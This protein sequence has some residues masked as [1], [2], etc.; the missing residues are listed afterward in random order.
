MRARILIGLSGVLTGFTGCITDS[1]SL[2]DSI[3]LRWNVPSAWH[4]GPS[5]PV[6]PR[7][8]SLGGEDLQA[9]IR[10]AYENNFDLQQARIRVEQAQLQTTIAGAAKRPTLQGAVD[11]SRSERRRGLVDGV[12]TTESEDYGL[13]LSASWELDL[14]G[15]LGSR[16]RAAIANRDAVQAQYD[17]A[18]LSLAGQVAKSWFNVIEAEMQRKI[19]RDALQTFENN[20]DLM[21]DRFNLGMNTA[22]DVQL[23]RANTAGAQRLLSANKQQRDALI[24]AL[25]VLLGTYPENTLSTPTVLPETL[26]PIPSGMP[27]EL[28]KRRPDVRAVEQRVRAAAFTQDEKEKDR[29]PSIRLTGRAG[30][31]SDELSSIAD[32]D[33]RF[34]NLA[35]GLTQPIFE[36]GRLKAVSERAALE[37]ERVKLDYQKI[38]LQ[39]FREVEQALAN[40]VYLREQVEA[41]AAA[42]KEYQEAEELARANYSKGLTNILTVLDAQRRYYQN[43]QTL[44]QLKNQ[45]IQ[46]RVDL[47]I[48]LGG[49]LE[50]DETDIPDTDKEEDDTSPAQEFRLKVMT[51]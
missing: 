28:L 7:L 10:R 23:S 45:R 5:V 47:I 1:G 36:A 39:A 3:S 44:V 42:V 17:S 16:T 34:S 19:A 46:N 26:D 24:R 11:A 32:W 2:E 48:A 12:M 38:A 35:A 22:L 49:H 9:L 21:R 30:T 20:Q 31:S 51:P 8:A 14:W 33:F 15:K 29:W 40:E 4:S 6:E 18:R 37:T 25:E 41:T 13:S 27:S 50:A 43:Q